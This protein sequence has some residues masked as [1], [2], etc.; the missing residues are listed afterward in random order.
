MDRKFL[1]GWVA[2]FVA[3]MFGSFVV[4]GVLLG[5]DYARLVPRLFRSPEDAQPLFPL[6]ILAHALLSGAFVWIYARGREARP[7]LG[8]GMRYGIA[9]ALLTAIPTYTIYY[10]VQPTPGALAIKQMI[11]DG[12]L[13]VLLGIIAAWVMQAREPAAR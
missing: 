8:Q 4:H 3:W 5:G 11:F 13:I 6:M 10:V 1:L 12:V 2:V 7:W 9:V